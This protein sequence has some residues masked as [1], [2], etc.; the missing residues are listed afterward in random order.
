MQD[1]HLLEATQGEEQLLSKDLDGRQMQTNVL[2][3]LLDGLAQID[4]HGLEHETQVVLPLERMQQLDDVVVATG[5]LGR[6]ELLQ[7]VSLLQCSATPEQYS[8]RVSE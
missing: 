8:T 4:R 6:V 5:A 7:E 2:S 3:A 1:R